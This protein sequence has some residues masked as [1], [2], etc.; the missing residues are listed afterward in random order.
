MDHVFQFKKTLMKAFEE[1]KKVLGNSNM[2][3]LVSIGMDSKYAYLNRHYQEVFNVIYGDLTG[4]HYA[5]TMHPEDT[6]TCFSVSEKAFHSPG[7]M[8]PAVIRKHDGKGGFIITRW[9]YKAMFDE[10]GNPTGIF[11]IGHDITE[12]VSNTLMLKSTQESLEKTQ[13][14]LTQI[15]YMQSHGIRKPV[16]NIL[17]L[18]AILDTDNLEFENKKLFDMINY[19]AK[20]ID[21]LLIKMI[22]NNPL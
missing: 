1:I 11:C 21:E 7:E 5:I 17:G 4:Q 3:Y 8:F 12:H 15:T 14:N 18:C 19:S 16:A 9:E 13:L 6:K 22:K 10:Y 2:Y 20:E